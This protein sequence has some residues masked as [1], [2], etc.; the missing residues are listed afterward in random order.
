LGADC[1]HNSEAKS[2]L[3]DLGAARIVVFGGGQSGGEVVESLLA[4]PGSMKELTLISRRHN[5]EPINDTPFSNQDRVLK[6]GLLLLAA[7][8]QIG[9]HV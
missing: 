1:F 6:S 9:L 7:E 8:L 2:R 3:S 5:F 4:D